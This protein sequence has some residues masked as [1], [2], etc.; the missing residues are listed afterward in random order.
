M[1]FAKSQ[2]A[3]EHREMEE[4]GCEV[5][6]GAPTNPAVKGYVKAKKVISLN[7]IPFDFLARLAFA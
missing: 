7:N 6:C 5:I 2:R 4:T 1:E 3:V